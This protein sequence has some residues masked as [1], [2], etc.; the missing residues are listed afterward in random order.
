MNQQFSYV[1]KFQKVTVLHLFLCI[2]GT[3][4]LHTKIVGFD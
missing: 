1:T 2:I 4:A 3:V